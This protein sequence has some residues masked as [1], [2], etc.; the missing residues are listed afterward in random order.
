MTRD[1]S[2]NQSN[3]KSIYIAGASSTSTTSAPT[4]I[5]TA[6]G[7]QSPTVNVGE[8][9]SYVWS[10]NVSNANGTATSNYTSSPSS[11]GSG[12]W[13]ATTPN[14]NTSATVASSQAG[15]SYT[16]TFTVTETA[17]GKTA[18]AGIS[19]AVRSV[20][21]AF[22][23]ANSVPTA[24]T[25]NG[26][27][28]V[29]AGS[30]QIYYGFSTDADGDAITYTIDWGDGSPQETQ[31]W[32]SGYVYTGSHTWSVAGTYNITVTARDDRGAARASS[33]GVRVE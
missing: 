22:T 32:G 3:S 4:A 29:F 17:T 6:N 30:R 27:G 18:S 9:I 2:G 25:I 1:A 16:I 5:L 8:T 11:C 21:G 13:S 15:C 28:I 31:R 23:T 14:G 10:S 24:P 12:A 33:Y 26:A 20:A 19:V 7:S